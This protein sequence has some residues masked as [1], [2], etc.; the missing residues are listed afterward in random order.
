MKISSRILNKFFRMKTESRHFRVKLSNLKE[1]DR[2]NVMIE[3]RFSIYPDLSLKNCNFKVLMGKL[4][5]SSLE[6]LTAVLMKYN[7]LTQKTRA[8]TVSIIC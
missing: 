2:K 8:T 6:G 4:E 5:E 3:S 7:D 1:V